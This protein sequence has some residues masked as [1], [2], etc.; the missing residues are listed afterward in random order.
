[1]E[2]EQGDILLCFFSYINGPR[3]EQDGTDG[4]P[5]ETSKQKTGNSSTKFRWSVSNSTIYIYTCT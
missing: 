3:V 1:M 2:I 4:H 5:T